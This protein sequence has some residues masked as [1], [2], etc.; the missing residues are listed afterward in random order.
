VYGVLHNR[1]CEI[2]GVWVALQLY[3][4]MGDFTIVDVGVWVAFEWTLEGYRHRTRSF[5]LRTVSMEN[6]Q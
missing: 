4:Y 5:L 6:L 3:G 1:G 2:L